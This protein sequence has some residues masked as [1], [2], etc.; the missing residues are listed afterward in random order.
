M[1]ENTPKVMTA[2]MMVFSLR[3][4]YIISYLCTAHCK[5]VCGDVG[6]GTAL[7]GRGFDSRWYHWNFSL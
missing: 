1:L 7:Q 6:W 4:T 3:A 2:L 5:N